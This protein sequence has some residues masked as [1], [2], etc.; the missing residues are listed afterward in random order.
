MRWRLALGLVSLAAL[1][2]PAVADQGDDLSPDLVATYQDNAQPIPTRIV[3]TEP[4]IALYWREGEAA[5]PRLASGGGTVR[6]EGYLKVVRPGLYRFSARVRG[7]VRLSVEGKPVLAAESTAAPALQQGGEIQL[8]AG[9]QPLVAEFT[10]PAGVAQ[11]QV[12]WESPFFRREPL[13]RGYLGHR[14][15][16]A[17]AGS[18]VRPLADR[19]VQ[20]GR[21]LAEEFG[22]LNCHK[23]AESSAAQFTPRR[24]PDLTRVGERAFAGWIYR[25]LEN[26]AKVLPGSTMP[27]LFTDDESGRK[28]RYAVAW[29]LASLAGPL[30]RGAPEPMTRAINT[31]V[32][33]GQQLFTAVGCAACHAPDGEPFQDGY[34]LMID[35]FPERRAVNLKQLGNK[36]TPQRLAAYLLDPLATD[37]G[38]RMPNMVLR[39]GEALDLARYL[40]QDREPAAQDSLPLPTASPAALV[41]AGRRLVIEKGCTGCHTISRGG[42]SLP[43]KGPHLSLAAVARPE[44]RE[45]GCLAASRDKQGKAP[46][47]P[48]FVGQVKDIQRFLESNTTGAGS[49]APAYLARQTLARFGCLACHTRNG[50]GGLS[51]RAVEA[52]RKVEKAEN[53]EAV[54]PP[55]LTEAGHKLRPAWMRQVL[56]HAARARPWMGLRMPQFGA[57]NVGHL[58]EALA[59]LDG[60]DPAE[61]PEVVPLSAARITAGRQL[62]GKSAFGCISCHDIAGIPN[63]GTR[64]PDLASMTERVRYDWYRRWLEQ[65]QR[66]QP[67]TRMPAVFSEGKSPLPS[68]LGGDA[69]AQAQAMWVY[70]SLGRSLPLPEGLEPPRGLVLTVADRPILLR[71]FMPDAGARAF[72]VGYPG[73]LSAAFDAATCRLA[74]LWTGNFVDASPVW[75]G[76]GGNPAKVLGPRAWTAPPGCPW[77]VSSSEGPPDFASRAKDPAYGAPVPEGSLY[78]GPQRLHFLGY[79]LGKAGTPS[80]RYAVD[81]AAGTLGIRERPEALTRAGLPALARH[82]EL[83]LPGG[84]TA[85]FLAGQAHGP[86]RVYD[87]DGTP[88]VVDLH[89]PLTELRPADRV[90][91][92]PGEGGR[93]ILLTLPEP[94]AGARWVLAHDK[95]TWQ[96]LIRVPSAAAA[97]AVRLTVVLRI[98]PRDE[99]ALLKE[100]LSSR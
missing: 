26:P 60:L 8:D 20:H 10:R 38:G 46:R 19:A 91:V 17:A 68:V 97:E 34:Q 48:F 35:R 39:Q 66:M 67:G 21:L 28:E 9:V 86:V 41:E 80:F 2:A 98:L 42:K 57:A 55:P 83:R 64:G 78:H 45:R 44:A 30:Q 99:P 77:A 4:T 81:G 24:G 1:T 3:R 6:W 52:L 96:V 84:R 63:S 36:T 22:C 43:V 71:T 79:D 61:K 27:A 51:F 87:A 5:D 33:R 73:G 59:A 95:G 85:W 70:L 62:V 7:R 15:D 40:C 56:T 88:Q 92:L 54:I 11:L 74:Y 16:P 94:P 49:P 32:A 69:D 18:G 100:F 29:Y 37:P 25:W 65:A 13:S 31:S 82:F 50:E 76:R 89:A 72:A 53:S 14:T 23:P 93:V 58:P 12:F 47:Y 75:D 90:L